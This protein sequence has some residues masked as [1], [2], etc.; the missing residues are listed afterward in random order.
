MDYTCTKCRLVKPSSEFKPRP[1]RKKGITSRCKVCLLEQQKNYYDRTRN[2]QNAQKR[3]RKAKQELVDYF[4]NK[5]LDCGNTFPNCVYDFHHLDPT[6][7]EGKT[8]LSQ[9]RKTQMLKE[10]ETC[11]LLCANCHRLRHHFH[12][13]PDEPKDEE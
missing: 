8:R 1:S 10:K 13:V 6:I 2:A 12:E 5:C 3:T 4:G 9:K 7:K 11:V